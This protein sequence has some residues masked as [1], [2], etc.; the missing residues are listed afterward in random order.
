MEKSRVHAAAS[1]LWLNS[2]STT[3]GSA[4]VERSPRSFSLRAICRRTRRMILPAGRA[5]SLS[6]GAKAVMWGETEKCKIPVPE[7]VLGSPGAFWMKSGVAIGPIFSLTEWNAHVRKHGIDSDCIFYNVI[8]T[9][10]LFSLVPPSVCGW[11]LCG[12]SEWR[13][14][15]D[16]LPSLHEADWPPQLQPPT[17]VRSE[18]PPPLLCS[19]ND[20]RD[21][22]L[23]F[24][25]LGSVRVFLSR[26]EYFYAFSWSKVTV[27]TFIILQKISISNQCCFF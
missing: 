22:T 9:S 8:M 14:S 21:K 20:L 11:T 6:L 4:R 13:S 23:L 16:T 19:T 26:N 25:S 5:K 10:D 3:L 18:P 27:K 1:H 7:R 15:T 12:L 2:T 17:G 24:K